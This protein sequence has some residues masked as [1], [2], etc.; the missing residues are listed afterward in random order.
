MYMF[1]FAFE[2][3]W[4]HW[5]QI[6]SWKNAAFYWVRS[7]NSKQINQKLKSSQAGKMKRENSIDKLIKN[8]GW[9]SISAF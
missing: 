8:K 1:F 3:E 5:K 7:L 9:P 4:N 2:L 6:N